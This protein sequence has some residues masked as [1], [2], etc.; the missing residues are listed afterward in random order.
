MK[1]RENGT[2][3]IQLFYQE[4]RRVKLTFLF[5]LLACLQV[6]A[7]SQDRITVNLQS[8][9]LKKALT[10][11]ERKSDY[12]FLY[13]EAVIINKPKIVL[14]V[15]DAEITS[16]LDKILVAN[17]INYRILNNNLIVLKGE[18]DNKI[19]IPDIRV[20]GKVTGTNGTPLSGV[21]ITIKGVNAGTTTDDA[22]NFALTVPNENS[23]LVFSYVGYNTQEIV[24]GNRTTINVSLIASANQLDQVV[25]VGYG[26][27][28]KVDVTGSVSQIKGDEISKQPVINAISGL[29]GKV[30]GVQITNNGAPGS[31]P[32][33]RIRGVGTVYGSRNPLYVVDGVWFDDISFLSPNDIENLSILKDA[34]AESIYGIRAANG[35]VLITTK[36]GRSGQPTV[37]YS[38]YAG[39]QKVTNAVPMAN[40][41]QYATLVNE[42]SVINGNPPVFADPSIYS[43]GTDWNRQIL[44]N[45]FITNQQV[46]VSG[47]S[48]RSTFNFSLSYLNQDGLVEKN[49][50]K[51]YTGRLQNDIQI[52]K[53]L[54][55]GYTAIGAYSQSKDIPGGIFREIYTAGPVVP[56]YY[57]DGTYGDPNDFRLGGGNN[58]NPQATLNFFDQ[59][60]KNYRLTGNAYAE[61]KFATHFTAKTSIGGEYGQNEVTGFTPIYTAT[62]AQRNARTSL[63]L[64]R[65]ET[66]NWILENTLTYNNKIGDHSFTVLAGQSAQRYKFY[67]IVASVLDVPDKSLGDRYFVLGTD[68]T[69]RV[70][71][72]GDLS[73][74]A[75][76]FGRLSYSYQSKYLLTA[77]IRADGS[78]KFTG[79]QRWG[80]FP[81]V[82][83]GWVVTSEK[84]MEGQQ[85]FDNLKLRGSW[86]Q[87]GNASVPSNISTLRVTQFPLAVYG[88]ATATSNSIASVVPP[89]TY[90]EKGVG[91]DVGLEASFLK[92]KLYIETDYYRRKTENAIFD[93]PILGSL[94][95]T[96]SSIL[97][98]QATFENKGFE[99]S[100][101]WKDVISKDISYTIGGNIGI[102]NNKVL[103]VSTGANP[104]YSGGYGLTG[105]ALATRTMVGR[106]I[107]EFYGYQ[108]AGIFQNAAQIAGSAQKTAK[109]GDFIYVD[110]NKDGQI[111]GLDRVPLGNPNPKSSYGINTNWIYKQFDL[112]LDF[113][114]VTGVSVYNANL[115]WRYGN[116]NFTLDF[117][118]NR[119][120]GEGTTNTYPSA[121]IGGG[122]NYLPNS[123]FVEDGSYFRI[124]NMQLGYTISKSLLDRW[125]IKSLRIYANAQNAFNFFKYRGFSPEIS[126]LNNSPLNAGIDANVYPLFA[127]YN[128]GVNL[129]F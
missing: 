95:M 57:A 18:D 86:G 38:G 89:V 52:F 41:S 118:N 116:E 73:T 33:I 24:V 9:D 34:S 40:G 82:G 117:Y 106:P 97:G 85:I 109:A 58:Y 39:W 77:S 45:A 5:I 27:Q 65:S 12:H 6:S 129:N 126:A 83:V 23:V 121:N 10:V 93:I 101:T 67:E 31:S 75:S 3:G 28:R 37:S 4:L 96:S 54:K 69:K 119:W 80:Y 2:A 56:V 104:I 63:N 51:R 50:Y 1:K 13:N 74:V 35:V 107:G 124:R 46:S 125:K 62:L 8:A 123:F 88:N 70:N 21:S 17:G 71:D 108:V 100:A 91:T 92:N 20:S 84:F 29:Q 128:F 48:E 68:S 76:Y 112:T 72:R 103:S 22:G 47:G 59:T 55:V 64:T 7:K 53:A 32:Q 42:L 36:K 87:I 43:K 25:I 102:N 14:N 113:Q 114:G 127:T 16:V 90:W 44:R 79:S 111:S 120:K 78:S 15:K 61:L 110:Q 11:I 98:N 105:G 115:G 66:R 94:G 19:E 30:A 122:A 26:T 99:F 49:N 81:S 60:S